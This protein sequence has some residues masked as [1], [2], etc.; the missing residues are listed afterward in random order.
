MISTTDQ[1][2]GKDGISAL[3]TEL[4]SMK[5][6]YCQY[7]WNTGAAGR[8]GV[9]VTNANDL[10]IKIGNITT[11]I[12]KETKDDYISLSAGQYFG[13]TK[14]VLQPSGRRLHT[15]IDHQD[16]PPIHLR[17]IGLNATTYAYRR[18]KHPAVIYLLGGDMNIDDPEFQMSDYNG[19]SRATR[20][21]PGNNPLTPCLT[22]LGTHLASLIAGLKY[23]VSKDAKVVAV[24]LMSLCS[25]DVRTSKVIRALDWVIENSSSYKKVVVVIPVQIRGDS[26]AVMSHMVQALLDMGAIVVAAA[27]NAAEDACALSPASV[28]GV[29]TVAAAHMLNASSAVP[30]EASNFGPCITLWAPGNQIEATSTL[31]VTSKFSGTSQ[32][33]AIVAGIVASIDDDFSIKAVLGSLITN[34]KDDIIINHPPLTTQL[35]AQLI[36]TAYLNDTCLCRHDAITLTPT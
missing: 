18:T 8:R 17:Y 32:A 27:G 9:S 13:T 30:W 15:N 31:N 20:A 5:L 1:S 36:Q 19:Q 23:G 11:S 2:L 10:L 12:F 4:L 24:S 21:F 22:E 14:A 25:E 33:M 6:F 16:D 35:F 3:C 7:H 28:P 26:R 29:I 34:S